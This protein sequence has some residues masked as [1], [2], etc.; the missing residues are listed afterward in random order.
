MNTNSR[1]VTLRF[2][3][4]TDLDDMLA[5]TLSMKQNLLG[6]KL[7]SIKATKNLRHFLNLLNKQSYGNSFRR[8]GKKIE[9]IPVLE[10]SYSDRLHYH[11]AVRNP[12]PEKLQWFET[13]IR[14]L[15]SKTDW[16][17]SEIDIQTDVDTGWINYIAKL[18]PHD[19]VDWENMHKVRRV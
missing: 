10:T 16:G 9:V 5:V 15:W 11:L 13:Q 17:Y 12:Y 7:D 1:N 6:E 19:E 14:R 4:E 2:L 18:G 8:H 3:L